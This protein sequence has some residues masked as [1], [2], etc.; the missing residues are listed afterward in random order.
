MN[1]APDIGS[2]LTYKGGFAGLLPGPDKRRPYDGMAELLARYE[3]MGVADLWR[4]TTPAPRVKPP[5]CDT[6]KE[7]LAELAHEFQ[8]RPMALT[9]HAL[10][11]AAARRQ[12]T[13]DVA[14]RLFL[15]LWEETPYDLLDALDMR[16]RLSAIQTFVD[17]G[18]TEIQR[19]AAARLTTF[20][21]VIKLYEAERLYSRFGPAAIFRVL[22][23]HDGPL[24]YGL[25]GYS[26]RKGDL[27]RNL[28]GTLWAEAEEDPLL[29]PLAC[30][31]LNDLN[32]ADE[33]LFH[34][35]MRMRRRLISVTAKKGD[36][37]GD[38]GD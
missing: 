30:R 32:R 7:K 6:A 15:A 22:G 35:L 29:R 37:K 25:K 24:P 31:L 27:D 11:I 36:G 18:T 28:L 34:R 20:F 21:Q 17:F 9:V 8:G 2:D 19:R 26:M 1:D 12:D 4:M 23:Q 16:W 3:A 10:T 38:A 13:P 14:G 33:G 5:R